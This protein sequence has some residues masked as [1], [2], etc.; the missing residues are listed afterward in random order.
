MI[1]RINEISTTI[2]SAVEEQAAATREVT[3]DINGTNQ[4]IGDA[5]TAANQVLS[6]SDGVSK[7]AADLEV[8]VNRFLVSVRAM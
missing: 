7:N 3:T 2:A 8:Q 5:S 1:N 4:A 6:A